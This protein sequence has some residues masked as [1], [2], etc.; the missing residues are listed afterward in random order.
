[1]SA[2]AFAQGC[3]QESCRLCGGALSSRFVLPVI[4]KY[5]VR[6]S[7]CLDCRSLQTESP[8]WLGEAYARNLSNLD[9]GAV[10]RNLHNLAACYAI[11]RLFRLRNALDFGGGDGL[12]CRLLR[13]Y[14]I[15]CF[16]RDKYASPAYAQG[17]TEPDFRTPD[18][19]LAFEVLEHL[20]DPAAQLEELF[21]ADPPVVLASTDLFSTQAQD[22]WYLAPESGQHVFFYSRQA[23]QLIAA[24]YRYE[25][26]VS[27]GFILFVKP[28]RLTRL[29]SLLARLLLAGRICRLIRARLALLPATG[30]WRDHL[31]QKS[32]ISSH[33]RGGAAD[34][35]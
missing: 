30:V 18:L 26:M 7:Q 9:T 4:G 20:T 5:D 32:T 33:A 34:G 19:V 3:P 35:R 24:K 27:G 15:N 2:E 1:M 14:G 29:R 12:L 8:Y 21:Q 25:L 22:W 31:Q 10:Q 13:D 11:A 6:Y 17:F 16:V 23:L 28:A